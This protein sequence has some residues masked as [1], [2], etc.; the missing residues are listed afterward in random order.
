MRVDHHFG[1]AQIRVPCRCGHSL[2]LL[3]HTDNQAQP[4]FCDERQRKNTHA[5]DFQQP[6]QPLR[7]ARHAIINNHLII[8]H[9]S[10]T[11]IDQTQQKV[12]F[13]A[14]RRPQQQQSIKT[15]RTR[16]GSAGGVKSHDG[17]NVA[18]SNG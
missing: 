3:A 16:P 6:L 14:A 11:A 13:P 7:R 2:G 18:N 15:V 5:T 1:Q 8:G 10:K 9:Q 12:G 4:G 17:R